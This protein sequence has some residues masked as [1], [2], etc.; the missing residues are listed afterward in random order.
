MKSAV[1]QHIHFCIKIKKCVVTGDVIVLP[2]KSFKPLSC[3]DW[4]SS[5]GRYEQV[6]KWIA[7]IMSTHSLMNI[8]KH[9]NFWLYWNV[10][11]L[12]LPVCFQLHVSKKILVW[13]WWL[14]VLLLLPLP[15][16]RWLVAFWQVSSL[17]GS[18]ECKA[19]PS[20]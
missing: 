6:P 16:Q 13:S 10:N 1:T 3:I 2:L 17:Q 20:C 15:C 14:S 18:W 9:V 7:S 11:I 19:V 4:F 12:F 8:F 5:E